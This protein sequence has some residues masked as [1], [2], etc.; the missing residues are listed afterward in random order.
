MTECNIV[1]KET[2]YSNWAMGSCEGN[3]VRSLRGFKMSVG[4]VLFLVN[5]RRQW[6]DPE[7]LKIWKSTRV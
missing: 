1:I 4:A 2:W 7:E 3:D 6:Q 5:V